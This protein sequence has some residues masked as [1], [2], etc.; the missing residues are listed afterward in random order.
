MQELKSTLSFPAPFPSISPYYICSNEAMSLS[1]VSYVHC[2]SDTGPYCQNPFTFSCTHP[3][4]TSPSRQGQTYL[5]EKPPHPPA[6]STKGLCPLCSWDSHWGCFSPWVITDYY[7]L[8]PQVDCKQFEFTTFLL[9]SLPHII[10]CTELASTKHLL[11]FFIGF[12]L[13]HVSTSLSST[14]QSLPLKESGRNGW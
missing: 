12:L 6:P 7:A 5:S 14:S 4:P 1:I 10:P 2:S 9:N 11:V 13:I 8:E 3:H